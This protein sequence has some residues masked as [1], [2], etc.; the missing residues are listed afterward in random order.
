MENDGSTPDALIKEEQ[1]LL[2]QL[3]RQALEAAVC[4]MPDPL[5]DLDSLPPRLQQPGASFVTLTRMGQLRG[6]IG[7]LEP[8]A[9]LA[10]D[11]CR[12]AVDAALQDY[13]FPPVKQYELGEIEIEISRLTLP[14]LLEYECAEE[15]LMKLQPGRDGVVLKDGPYR[16]TFLPQVW[17]KLPDCSDFLDHLCDKMGAPHNLWRFKKLEV[18][19]YQ[20]E[21]FR[22]SAG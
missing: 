1:A 13:R 10:V 21:E 15:L 11:V 8:I 6:C 22:E 20:I 18:Q 17:E 7:S 5:I 16:A 14:R 3:A 4:G 12:H 2:L 19:T 9:P